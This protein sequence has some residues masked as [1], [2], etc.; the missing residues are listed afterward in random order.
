MG[1]KEEAGKVGRFITDKSETVLRET[2]AEALHREPSS[3]EWALAY[4]CFLFG[5]TCTA[6]AMIDGIQEHNIIKRN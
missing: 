2:V 6:S 5:A 4:S 1:N 3:T